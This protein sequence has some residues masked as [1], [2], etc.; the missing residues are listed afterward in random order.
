[1]PKCSVGI[2]KEWQSVRL[3]AK[4]HTSALLGW[5]TLIQE[6]WEPKHT[7]EDALLKAKTYAQLPFWY[8]KFCW[9]ILSE[10]NSGLSVLDAETH[11]KVPIWEPKYATLWMSLNGLDLDLIKYSHP[12]SM[13]LGQKISVPSLWH[14]SKRH[15]TRQRWSATTHVPL[16]FK[17]PCKYFHNSSDS[18]ARAAHPLSAFAH[19]CD[20]LNVL[21]NPKFA[22]D[23]STRLRLK[24]AQP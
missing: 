13:S 2:Q 7:H 6:P 18:E 20:K 9:C 14:H 12:T 8:L 19:V 4:T 3:G 11:P 22:A 17:P 23:V 21:L 10:P 15:K 24:R 16:K 5:K 1:M